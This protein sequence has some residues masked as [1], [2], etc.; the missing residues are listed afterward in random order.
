MPVQVDVLAGLPLFK[1]LTTIEIEE[2][3]SHLDTDEAGDKA[4]LIREGD[5]PNHPIY[6][7]LDGTV[8][9]LK[10]G[11][12]GRDHVISSL[13]APSVFGEIEV[14]AH[15]PAIAG[16]RTTSPVKLA[17]LNRGVFDELCAGNR[18][19]I[20][21]VIK[22]LASTLAYRLAATDGRL[23]AYFGVTRPDAETV[24]QMHSFLYST[25]HTDKDS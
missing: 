17:L 9:V 18:P 20:L 23:A 13:S 15:R 2:L 25:W 19:C 14:L 4:V 21:K 24:G 7:L 3:A 10:H 1:G 16:V 8:E 12:D 5:E 22:N 6:I 11:V